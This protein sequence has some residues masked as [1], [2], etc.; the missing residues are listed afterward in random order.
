MV[1]ALLTIPPYALPQAREAI[2]NLWQE[3]FGTIAPVLYDLS[4]PEILKGVEQLKKLFILWTAWFLLF[5]AF[6]LVLRLLL[7]LLGTLFR[8]LRNDRKMI[9]QEETVEKE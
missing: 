5:F 3:Y 9:K 6:E 4:Q 2:T 8:L 7:L 1:L